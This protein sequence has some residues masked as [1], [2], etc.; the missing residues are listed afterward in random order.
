MSPAYDFERY[1]VSE[2]ASRIGAKWAGAKDRQIAAWVAD[3]DFPLAPRIHDVLLDV[4]TRDDLGYPSGEMT[5]RVQ[6][7]FAERMETRYGLTIDPESAVVLSDVM[8]AVALSIMTFTDPGDGVVFFTPTYPPFYSVVQDAGRRVIGS[9]LVSGKDG[10]EIDHD[11]LTS[12]VERER[13]RCIL[14][15]N[16]QNPTG[17]V[18]DRDELSF[19]A[20][21]ACAHNL[22]V[23]SDE[24]HADLVLNGATHTPIAT[25]SNDIAQ[26]TITLGSATKA[27][28]V[29]SLRCAVA[30]FGSEELASRFASNPRLARGGVGMLGML[31]ALTAWSECD[32]WL[33][34]LLVY[35]E[36]NRA[37]INARVQDLDGV[38]FYPPQATYLAW[39]DFHQ[40]GLGADPAAALEERAG[41]I[42]SSGMSFG[43]GGEGHA[44]L[45]FA[46]PRPILEDVLDRIESQL[47]AR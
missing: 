36:G 24:I 18:F 3:M 37:L 26:R 39:L 16:P 23:I 5:R 17:R 41:V 1:G 32:P 45:N 34:A 9:E 42:M 27:F 6:V 11:A 13:P 7:G 28:N 35:L 47:I 31:A 44:R 10:Y 30:C 20:T 12:L 38:M 19:I 25:I 15:C 14:L 2:L 43:Q 29:A 21:I 4:L 33:E 22:V 40:A 46:T 8:Q